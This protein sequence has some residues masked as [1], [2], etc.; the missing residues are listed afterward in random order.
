MYIEEIRNKKKGQRQ[1]PNKKAEIK[2]LIVGPP[3]WKCTVGTFKS[4]QMSSGLELFKTIS[5]KRAKKNHSK[6]RPGSCLDV[7]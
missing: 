2:V 6:N 1:T 7:H 5:F 4:I 3:H